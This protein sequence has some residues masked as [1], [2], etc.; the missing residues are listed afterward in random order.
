[1]KKWL[2]FTL[3]GTLISSCSFEQKDPYILI[4]K[5]LQSNT[6][7]SIRSI[8]VFD[9]STVWA[10]GNAGTILQSHDAGENWEILTIPSHESSDYR[11]IQLF[12][13]KKA[14]VMS[15]GSPAKISRTNNGGKS[16]WM[17]YLNEDPDIFLDGMAFLNDKIGI[18][19]GDAIG[20]RI[21]ILRTVN[22]GNSWKMIPEAN[23]PQALPNEGGFA[24]S[25]TSIRSI[26][27][28]TVIIGFGYPRGR[29]LR[30][31]D[32]G[33]TWEFYLSH[34]GNNENSRGV[35]S[36]AFKTDANSINNTIGLAVGGSWEDP[37]NSD[38]VLSRS[39]DGGVHW[40]IVADNAPSGYRSAVGFVPNKK[41]AICTGTN[42]TDMSF[43]DGLTWKSFSTEG[44]NAIG[45]AP[46]GKFAYLAGGNGRISRISF[47]AQ[48]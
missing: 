47:L 20:T 23:L 10:T 30:S 48:E 33:L 32:K 15:I 40:T 7:V 18:A 28:S 1:M 38:L 26:N 17:T 5:P 2:Y 14:V 9:D 4:Q 3:V 45:F 41:I 25:G 27:D 34:L 29:V 8:Q 6:E 12:G 11:D 21:P 19:F 39:K 44:F 13:K 37:S 42:G 35:Y 43:D 16:W 31:T 22:G 46:S 24:A 36:L